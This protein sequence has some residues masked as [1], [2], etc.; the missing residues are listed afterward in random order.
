MPAKPVTA[1]A[2]AK[3]APAAKAPAAATKA[4]A[5]KA[6]TAGK[7]AAAPIVTIRQLAAEIA[8]SHEIT[9]QQA[10]K[11]V[12]GVVGALAEHLKSGSRLRLAGLGVLEVKD[13]PARKGR[14]PATG[15]EIDIAASKKIAFRPAKELKEAI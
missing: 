8:E 14:N 9:K 5:A 4:P 1:K 6:A 12:N 7:P 10:D 13:R 2:S 15:E 3:A 11:L